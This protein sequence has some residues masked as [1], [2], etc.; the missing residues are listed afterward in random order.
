[1]PDSSTRQPVRQPVSSPARD[2]RAVRVLVVDDDTSVGDLLCRRL[3]FDGM[4]CEERTNAEDG[5]AAYIRAHCD[6]D[7]FDA[8]LIDIGLGTTRGQDLLTMLRSADART[9]IVMI[10]GQSDI[11]AAIECVELGADGFLR[12]PIKFWDLRDR[13]TTAIR[14]RRTIFERA[15]GIE[16]LGMRFGS[17][18]ASLATGEPTLRESDR[19]VDAEDTEEQ[20]RQHRSMP[21]KSQQSPG[22]AIAA[23]AAPTAPSERATC[24]AAS[25]CP[26]ARGSGRA[27]SPTGALIHVAKSLENRFGAPQQA[28]RVTTRLAKVAA[29]LASDLELTP[30]DL[31]AVCI[32]ARVEELALARRASLLE[33]AVEPTPSESDTKGS[34]WDPGYAAR[35]VRSLVD[36]I[37]AVDARSATELAAETL[38]ACASGS[39][40]IEPREPSRAARLA[41]LLVASREAT[42]NVRVVPRSPSIETATYERAKVALER[43][44]S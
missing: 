17:Y 19:N 24:A 35:F 25:E 29:L 1:M 13:L 26:P 16:E 9:A 41:G 23:A 42:T 27:I 3:E 39:G 28:E 12:K 20:P 6:D 10:S 4:R 43:L 22:R 11:S 5:L 2:P 40:A 21:D 7:P 33:Q 34:E 15:P 30:I 31:E 37:D 18:E 44:G 36:V 8:V 38:S 32:A 14:K